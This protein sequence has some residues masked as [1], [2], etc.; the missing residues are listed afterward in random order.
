MVRLVH[1]VSGRVR[2]RMQLVIRF[3]F[4]ADIPWVKKNADGTGLLAICGQDMA[5]LR[6]PVATRGEGLTTVA[7]FE[8]GEGDIVPFVLTYGPSHLPLPIIPEPTDQ[9]P[10]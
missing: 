7:E 4:G 9:R 8:V 10:A 2:L 1:G 6:T 3:G 5:V